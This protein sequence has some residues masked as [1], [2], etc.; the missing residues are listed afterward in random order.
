M[1]STESELPLGRLEALSD[2]VF[3]IAIALLVLEVGVSAKAGEHLLS[4]ILHQWPSYLA[5]VTSFLTI[6][7]GFLL[8]TVECCRA[9]DAD[10]ACGDLPQA[11]SWRSRAAGPGAPS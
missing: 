5:Y 10:N 9:R 4:S 11:L 2:G 3:P 8:P 1:N 6:G 7:V